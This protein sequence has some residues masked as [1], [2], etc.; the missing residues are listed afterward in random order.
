MFII[1]HKFE[2]KKEG[3]NQLFR[4]NQ[5]SFKSKKKLK[6]RCKQYLTKQHLIK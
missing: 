1:A 4:L 3:D 6:S 2:C 5:N